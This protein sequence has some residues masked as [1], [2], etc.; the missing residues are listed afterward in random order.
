[1]ERPAQLVQRDYL[2]R[3][4]SFETLLTL[5]QSNPCVRV[6]VLAMFSLPGFQVTTIGRF[7][8]TAEESTL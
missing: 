8:V 5:T 3:L 1:M 4:S 7:W 6:N 2:F